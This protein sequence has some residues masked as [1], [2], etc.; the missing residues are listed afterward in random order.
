MLAVGY[1][2][3]KN[4]MFN[5][6]DYFRFKK[7]QCSVLVNKLE[8]PRRKGGGGGAEGG[9]DEEGRLLR[10]IIYKNSLRKLCCNL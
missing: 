2:K 4:E 7:M 1:L 8:V 3:T 6:H 10:S 5:P 9:E